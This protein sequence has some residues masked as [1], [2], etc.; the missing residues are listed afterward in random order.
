MRE[1]SVYYCRSCGHYAFFQLQNNA[2]CH[3]CEEPMILLPMPYQKFMDIGYEDRDRLISR[4]IINASPT[5]VQR[6]T[7]PGKLFNQREIIGHLTN[8]VE[9]L[10]EENK[11][12]S[13][14]VEWMHETIWTLIRKSK[15]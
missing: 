11:E 15:S 1:L 14:T 9:E 6:L 2:V 13:D 4:E 12:L 3:K 10:E 8:R 7:A 5:L